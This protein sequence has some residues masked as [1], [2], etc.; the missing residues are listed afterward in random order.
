[1]RRIVSHLSRGPVAQRLERRT[2]NPKVPS[3]NLG[4]PIE[5]SR[6]A[7]LRAVGRAGRS[8]VRG[9]ATWHEM[10]DASMPEAWASFL[11]ETLASSKGLFYHDNGAD[12]SD[13]QG[14]TS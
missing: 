5:R 7:R 4:G 14:V 13:C 3:S 9:V 2:H 12:L 11:P 1:M 8:C 10:R 6:I